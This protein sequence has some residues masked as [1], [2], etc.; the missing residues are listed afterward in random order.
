MASIVPSYLDS[1][2]R[3][4]EKSFVLDFQCLITPPLRALRAGGT[5]VRARAA[6]RRKASQA[7]PVRKQLTSL[8]RAVLGWGSWAARFGLRESGLIKK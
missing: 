3:A 7:K 8:H 2:G 5:A 1:L 6:P 4:N